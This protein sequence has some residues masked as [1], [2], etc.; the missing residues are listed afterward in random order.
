MSLAAFGM[1]LLLSREGFEAE[2]LD[3]F[4]GLNQ[5][6]RWYAFL[7]LLI[8]F[9]LAGIPVMVGFWAKLAVLQAAFAAGYRVLVVAAVLFSLVGAY[10]Y[11][12]VVKLMYFDEPVDHTPIVDTAE[13]RA[14][15]TVNGLAMLVL[16]LAPG[17]LLTLCQR[18]VL[19]SL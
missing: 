18:A 6:N 15:M 13:Q 11:L 8:L 3:D 10:Y 19:T 2:N 7:M 12:R 14:L 16:G 4:R 1:V 9:S 5:R 17:W